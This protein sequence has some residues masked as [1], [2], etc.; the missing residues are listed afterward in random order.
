M[1]LVRDPM[2][3]QRLKK[4]LKKQELN[5]QTTSTEINLPYITTDATMDQKLV[6]FIIK[7]KI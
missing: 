6:H 7:S 4:L 2:A 5:Y 3:L 1:D